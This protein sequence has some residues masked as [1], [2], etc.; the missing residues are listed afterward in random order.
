MQGRL[1]KSRR[2]LLYAAISSHFLV[3]YET[4]RCSWATDLH[5]QAM[6]NILQPASIGFQK[7]LK[8]CNF[9]KSKWCNKFRPE[10]LASARNASSSKLPAPQ[11]IKGFNI[12]MSR[13][14]RN[15]A[16][17]FKVLGCWLLIWTSKSNNRSHS[18]RSAKGA[19]SYLHLKQQLHRWQQDPG[20]LIQ[21]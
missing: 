11:F 3:K 13:S 19:P 12:S 6:E 17:A 21:V 9:F 20:N 10:R 14:L 1:Q 4:K 2:H 5:G 7:I 8:V 16:D 18:A 15:M